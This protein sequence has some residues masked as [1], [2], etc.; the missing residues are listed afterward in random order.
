MVGRPVP[1]WVG[2]LP[3]LD[4]IAVRVEGWAHF[5]QG[6]RELKAA[7]AGNGT[8]DRLLVLEPSQ[9]AEV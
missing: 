7:F 6:A 5:T 1:V 9:P 3:H 4:Q 8:A 2:G